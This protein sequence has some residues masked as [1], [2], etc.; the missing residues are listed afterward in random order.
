MT[1]NPDHLPVP[2][3]LVTPRFVVR[4]QRPED[5]DLDFEA[6]MD[7]KAELRDWS[8]SEW[9]EDD[10]T[11][12]ANADDLRM[13]IEEHEQDVAYG[14]SVFEPGF[15]RLLGSI[16]VDAVPPLFEGRVV[17]EAVAARLAPYDARLEYW[18]R[19]GTPEDLER[20]LVREVLGWLRGAW[21][22]RGVVLGSRPAM[23][24]RRAL[25]ES[26]GL[27]PVAVLAAADGSRRF[28]LH[29]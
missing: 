11:P 4:R 24:R 15:G 5:A 13:H 17:D 29:A 28:H 21:W 9:P 1:L 14:F 3:L 25:Y 12:E 20:E 8:A 18:L 10:F 19:R 7:S 16:Y 23:E 26:L 27:A 2:A 22:F 6:V